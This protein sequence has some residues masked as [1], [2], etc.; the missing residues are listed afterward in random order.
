ME[1]NWVEGLSF[2][3]LTVPNLTKSTGVW[4]L[5]LL[6]HPDFTSDSKVHAIKFIFSSGFF[7]GV[8]VGV[9]Y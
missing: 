7:F 6:F 1:E 5:R 9:A 3:N 2:L 4:G 8:G